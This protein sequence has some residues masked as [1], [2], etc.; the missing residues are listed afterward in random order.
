MSTIASK[1][2]DI[3]VTPGNPGYNLPQRLGRALWAPMWLMGLMG[4]TAGIVTAGVRAAAVASGAGE[5]TLAAQIHLVGGFMFIGFASVFAAISFAIA[6]ILGVFRDGGGRVQDTLG[7]KVYS[8]KMPPTAKAF[9]AL[10]M[11]AMM[12]ILVAVVV[13]F[14]TAAGTASGTIGVADS[15][16]TA[17]VLEAVRRIGVALY[18][19]AIAL[20]LASITRVLRFR[21]VRLRELPG[22][23]R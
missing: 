3:E 10:M 12:A 23:T 19:V 7:V 18:L 11:V 21:A 1:D 4:F 2:F 20:G 15:E 13:H 22:L 16:T 5:A 6:R 8:L 17:I 9:I 14:V